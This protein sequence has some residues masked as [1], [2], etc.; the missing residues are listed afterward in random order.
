MSMNGVLTVCIVLSLV[1][2][3]CADPEKNLSPVHVDIAVKL[4]DQD[5]VDISIHNPSRDTSACSSKTSWVEYGVVNDALTVV[6]SDGKHWTFTGS[7]VEPSGDWR[8]DTLEIGPDKSMRTIVHIRDYYRPIYGASTEI[9]SVQYEPR[10]I[11]C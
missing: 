10:F 2:C 11:A 9:S 6:G 5:V 7:Y 1:V 8:S 3:S 4:L